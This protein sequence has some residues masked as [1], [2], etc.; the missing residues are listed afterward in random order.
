M[1]VLKRSLQNIMLPF[2]SYCKVLGVLVKRKWSWRCLM[3]KDNPFFCCDE[4]GK[5]EPLCLHKH[6]FCTCLPISKQGSRSD[7]ELSCVILWYSLFFVVF[8]YSA[9]MNC[10]CFALV[11]P[12][13]FSSNFFPFIFFPQP[14]PPSAL[15]QVPYEVRCH[16]KPT[17]CWAVNVQTI[18]NNI[19]LFE[20]Y[21]RA[22]RGEWF[23]C[24]EGKA[25]TLW[26]KQ[27]NS[28]YQVRPEPLQMLTV[29]T[30]FQAEGQERVRSCPNLNGWVCLWNMEDVG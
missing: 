26:M 13:S 21:A 8:H 17:Q 14:A 20:K 3:M 30:T 12:Y 29:K 6:K 10:V 2:I 16:T 5:E 23:S 27:E 19:L 9:Q 15:L 28:L 25:R 4:Q 18:S 22:D 7:S 11:I 1:S 24:P